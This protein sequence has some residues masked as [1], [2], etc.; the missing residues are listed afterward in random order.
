[1]EDEHEP[2]LNRESRGNGNSFVEFE[3]DI[4]PTR[5]LGEF[6]REFAVESKK[7]WYLAGPAIFTSICQYSLG[8]ITQAFAGHLG[9]LELAAVSMENS[10]IAGFS[11][12]LLLGMGSALET[13]CG[14]AYGAGQLDMLGIYMQRSWVILITTALILS[15]FYVFATPFLILIGQDHRIAAAAGLF[16][17]YMI[18]QL[19]AYAVYFPI[20]KFLQAQS[21]MMSMAVIASIALLL[22]TFFSWLV[23][24]KLNWGMVGAAVVLNGSWWFIV[25]AQLVYIFCGSC[26]RAWSGFSWMAFRNLWGFV[27][28]SVESAVMLCMNILGWAVMVAIGSNAATR[29][30]KELFQVK[31]IHNVRVSN[32]LGAGHPRTAKFSVVVVVTTSFILGFVL[33]MI[34]LATKNDWPK[35]FTSSEEVKNLVS[36]LTPLL[37]I[38]IVVNNVQPVFSGVAIGAGWQGLVA[39]VNIG[40]YYIFGIPLGL[41]L[42]YKLDFGVKGIWNGMLAGTVVQTLILI[43]MT[44]R[45]NWNKE[46]SIA[47]D[48]LKH[49][50]GE[51]AKA[52]DA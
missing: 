52:N 32:E 22:H 37:C 20:Q 21:R 18:P 14:Q 1:M 38:S 49:W 29:L 25:V 23:M 47:G 44:D 5:S 3:G 6:S 15:I 8:A 10:V 4:E 35:A 11:F 33:S 2:L 51:V 24:I 17:L 7:L 40:C 12:G 34:L 36:E 43:W 27:R 46:A 28:L 45:T 50:G 31:N 19:F 16:S 48:R 42:G 26:G 9:T 13:L 30:A 39:Y 41:L